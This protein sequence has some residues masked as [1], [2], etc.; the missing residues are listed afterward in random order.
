MEKELTEEEKYVREELT[1]L[2][3]QLQINC[4]KTLGAAYEKY[5]GDLLALCITFFLEKPIEVQVKAF[6]EG[7]AE[8]F[9]TFMMGMQSKSSY[10]KWYHEYRK[11]HENQ[12]EYFTDHYQYDAEVEDRYEDDDMMLC[13]KQ[14]IKKLNPYEKMLIEKKVIKGMRFVDIAE[15]FDIPYSSL[16]STLKTTLK[17]LKEQCRHFSY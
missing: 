3:P 12:R 14:A 13:I 8:N 7:T 11:H 9:I 5:G 2:Y 6:K 10:S 15:D 17:K 4:Q 1:K 16:A